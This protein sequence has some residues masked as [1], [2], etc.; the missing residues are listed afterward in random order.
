MSDNG[1]LMGSLCNT[2]AATISTTT[3]QLKSKQPQSF[4][5]N[6]DDSN[7]CDNDIDNSYYYQLDSMS[8]DAV[9]SHSSSYESDTSSE[10]DMLLAIRPN[11]IT[12]LNSGIDQVQQLSN[13]QKV[14]HWCR[15]V[16]QNWEGIGNSLL[17]NDDN[18]S[19]SIVYGDN[20][21]DDNVTSFQKINFDDLH[22]FYKTLLS[23]NN[24]NNN[25]I[26]ISETVTECLETLLDRMNMNAD[27]MT[28]LVT[29][30]D[31]DCIHTIV[32][33]CRSLLA[34]M[35]WIRIQQQQSIEINRSNVNGNGSGNNDDDYAKGAMAASGDMWS[36]ILSHK[37]IQVVNKIAC[38]RQ[39][40][41]R[42]VLKQHLA[43]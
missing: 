5:N 41:I 1:A 6:N 19:I 3:Q 7:S 17:C 26:R 34:V 21:H 33:W 32:E 36:G 18:D 15:A 23:R 13:Q 25:G 28:S 27:G 2:T 20:E 24:N 22:Q 8:D 31:T 9:S 14:N 39:S 37:F 16:F 10:E 4:S 11:I 43:R 30:Q 12:R 38:H 29:V 35:E 40:A 42:Q